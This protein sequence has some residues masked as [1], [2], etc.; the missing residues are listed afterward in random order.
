LSN[1]YLAQMANGAGSLRFADSTLGSAV[2]ASYVEPEELRSLTDFSWGKG[3]FKKT[4]SLTFSTEQ[5]WN[6]TNYPYIYTTQ[7]WGSPY[8]ATLA[9]N[10]TTAPSPGTQEQWTI[11]DA[12]AAPNAATGPVFEGLLL[13]MD[14]E[15]MRVMSVSGTTVTVERGSEGTTPVAHTAGPITVHG[16]FACDLTKI[17]IQQVRQLV[18]SNDGSG[19]AVHHLRTGNVVG[20]GGSGWPTVDFTDGSV[21]GSLNGYGFIA[22]VTSA[23]SFII[24]TSHSGQS[25]ACTLGPSTTYPSAPT[26]YS[27]TGCTGS[28]QSPVPGGCMPYEFI[29]Q[30]VAAFPGC[31]LHLN[32][33]FAINNSCADAIAK[34]I[35]ANLPAGRNVWI[36]LDDEPWNFNFGQQYQYNHMASLFM[37]PS[38]MGYEYQTQR[39]GELK[40]R[41]INIF[42]QGG[43]NRG[44]EIKMLLNTQMGNT[45]LANNYFAYAQA[46]GFV[47]D[48]MAQAP[49]LGPDGSTASQINYWTATDDQIAGDIWIHDLWYNTSP[50][51]FGNAMAQNMLA[52]IQAYNASTGNSCVLYGYEG[53]LSSC[54]QPLK[55]TLTA[56]ISDS[57]TLTGLSVSVAKTDGFMVGQY[58]VVDYSTNGNTLYMP[59]SPAELM[60]ITAINGNST[61]N[62]TTTGAATWT[63]NRITPNLPPG[64]TAPKTHNSGAPVR[65]CFY[66]RDFDILYNPNWRQTE[67]DCYAWYQQYYRLLNI[68]SMYMFPTPCTDWTLYYGAG[69][70]PGRGDNSDG[71][72]TN[73]QYR[74]NPGTANFKP[75]TWNVHAHNVSVRGQ[76]FLDW[77]GDVNVNPQP[78]SPATA[79]RKRRFFVPPIR[80]RKALRTYR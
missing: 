55:T 51:C 69:Q 37:N 73:C 12:Q 48:A 54:F 26:S 66:E 46:H 19:N 29:A 72:G 63:V 23:N 13:E 43:A 5:A 45:G 24:F 14:G 34:A 68:Y 16:R 57:T 21:S 36:E 4:L 22:W 75:A 78:P 65:N 20:M 49:Y 1:I 39:T 25:A 41:F 42:N 8:T 44:G 74:C 17:A 9:A 18:V 15:K 76:A 2:T 35:F 61:A 62:Y 7:S 60:Q 47:V 56:A 6:P 38:S 79:G 30:V 10:V 59:L 11:S 67:Y 77:N 3:T 53:D 27:L 58:V 33:G 40:Q 70:L 31:D 28:Y 64:A 80:Y 50:N 52:A 71:L 32:L